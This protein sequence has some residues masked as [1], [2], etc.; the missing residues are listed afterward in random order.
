MINPALGRLVTGEVEAYRYLPDSTQQFRD[1]QAVAMVMRQVGYVDV[2]YRLFMFGTIAIHAGQKP[3]SE[4]TV[5]D[6][7]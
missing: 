1:P 7:T 2:S 4:P 5:R 3:W 6:L